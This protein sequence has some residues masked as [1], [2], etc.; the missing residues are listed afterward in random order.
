M[1]KVRTCNAVML[2]IML[3]TV[4]RRVTTNVVLMLLLIRLGIAIL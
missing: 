1:K 2:F 3:F 4:V